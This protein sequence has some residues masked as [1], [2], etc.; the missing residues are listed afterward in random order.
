MEKGQ[1]CYTADKKVNWYN[2][3]GEQYGGSLKK[4]NIELPT[5]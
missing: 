1:P 5:I 3:Y 4:L 2:H